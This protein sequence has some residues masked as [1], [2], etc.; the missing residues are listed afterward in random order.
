MNLA[1]SYACK[2]ARVWAYGNHSLAW[3]EFLEEVDHNGNEQ[4]H[5]NKEQFLSFLNSDQRK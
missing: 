4:V 2:D 3:P 1:L 5:E